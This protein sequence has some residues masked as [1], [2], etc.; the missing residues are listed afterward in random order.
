MTPPLVVVFLHISKIDLNDDS[1]RISQSWKPCT[2]TAKNVNR[3]TTNSLL[4]PH[5]E[6]SAAGH[7][8]RDGDQHLLACHRVLHLEL[9]SGVGARRRADVEQP[10]LLRWLRRGWSRRR[11]IPVRRRLE[12]PQ[13]QRASTQRGAIQG[14]R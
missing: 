1:Y 8:L 13:P 3:H 11:R 14:L 7:S 9:H 2:L 5:P 12:T 10:F 4:V 6:Q